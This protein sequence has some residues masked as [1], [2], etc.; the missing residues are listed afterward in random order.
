MAIHNNVSENALNGVHQ[1]HVILFHSVRAR[2]TN[3]AVHKLALS[4]LLTMSADTLM[5]D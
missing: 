2:Q 5:P 1:E 3:H 4:R